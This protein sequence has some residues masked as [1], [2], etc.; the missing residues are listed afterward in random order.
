VLNCAI[1]NT[2]FNKIFTDPT[3]VLLP[4]CNRNCIPDP[5]LAKILVCLAIQ[6]NCQVKDVR[7]HLQMASLKQYGKVQCLD[8]GDVMNASALVAVGDD[9]RDA[10]FIRVSYAF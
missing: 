10:T 4:P 9:R 6:F 3:C 8:G 7:P 2:V 5:L 1:T